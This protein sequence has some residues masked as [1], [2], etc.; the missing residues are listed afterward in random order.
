MGFMT[1]KGGRP[2]ALNAIIRKAGKMEVKLNQNMNSDLHYI[3]QRSKQ[4]RPANWS[5]DKR[6]CCSCGQ[7]KDVGQFS[8]LYARGKIDARCRECKREKD[9]QYRANMDKETKSRYSVNWAKHRSTDKAKQTA[10][11]YRINK[12]ECTDITIVKCMECGDT[13]LVKRTSNRQRCT[14]CQRNYRYLSGKDRKYCPDCGTHE[15]PD[16][17]TYCPGCADIRHKS[18]KNTNRRRYRKIFG[19]VS[20]YRKRARKYNVEFDPSVK[21]DAVFKRD[22]MK[23]QRCG[24]KVQRNDYLSE[25][26]AE[27]DHIVPLSKGGPHT[28]SNVQTLCRACNRDK[29][30]K[31]EG[32]LIMLL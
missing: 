5:G 29:S 13:E 7:F 4:Y 6:K 18:N 15:V 12:N 23:C 3:I 26:A 19:N 11:E 8:I 16:F 1:R 14:P 17:K 9:A 27:L 32:Q 28:W 24:I 25:N 10:I 2:Y 21:K 30:D 31:L 22:K 20:T